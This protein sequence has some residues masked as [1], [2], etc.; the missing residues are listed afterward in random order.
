MIEATYIDHM[1]SDLSVVNAA[2]VSFG[3]KS[4]WEEQVHPSGDYADNVLSERDA[5]LI[6][7]L[8]KHKHYS[9]FG[10]AFA[11]FHVRCPIY[12]HAQ[13]EKHKF[14]RVNTV[15]RRYV[16]TPPE[17][18]LPDPFRYKAEDKKQGSTG[19]ANE[20]VM[21]DGF[22]HVLADHMEQSKKLYA[23]MIDRGIAPELARGWLPQ[24]AYTEFYWSGS[25]DAFAS[26]CQLRCK[27][28]TQYESRL[29]ADQISEKMGELF[30]VSWAALMDT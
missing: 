10:H 22:D 6:R 14:L 27:P 23:D 4:E 28:D 29:V 2:R 8:A 21:H 24:A 11:S 12:V 3:K 15:S 19:N 25:L 9:P 20:A 26:M 18:Y 1:G 7:Y 16:N 5:K 13:L 30:P 17:F